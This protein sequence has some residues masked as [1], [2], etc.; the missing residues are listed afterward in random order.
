VPTTVH[1]TIGLRCALLV[2]ACNQGWLESAAW[3]DFDPIAAKFLGSVERLVGSS[4]ERAWIFS[5]RRNDG[6]YADTYGRAGD[7][8]LIA[9]LG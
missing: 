6:S 4:H 1:S 8:S 2:C 5:G 9:N 3:R 7:S